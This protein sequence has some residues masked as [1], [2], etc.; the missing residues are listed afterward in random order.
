MASHQLR[1]NF[2]K[3]CGASSRAVA[4]LNPGRS[5]WLHPGLEKTGAS[6]EGLPAQPCA[7]AACDR[8]CRGGGCAEHEYKTEDE[9]LTVSKQRPFTEK[10]K[11]P[12]LYLLNFLKHCSSAATSFLFR[13]SGILI[14]RCTDSAHRSVSKLQETGRGREVGLAAVHG[15][16]KS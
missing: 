16:A 7:G 13:S 11:S 3:S 14:R 1:P 2:R 10:I 12:Q 8:R 5:T 9:P 6:G 4:L 15:V